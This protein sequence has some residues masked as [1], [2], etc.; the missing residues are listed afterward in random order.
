MTRRG[1]TNRNVRGSSRD[2]HRQRAEVDE[3]MLTVMDKASSVLLMSTKAANPFTSPTR[4][5]ILIV[6][7]AVAAFT[8]LL[9]MWFGPNQVAAFNGWPTVV[10]HTAPLSGQ[11]LHDY[12]CSEFVATGHTDY[13]AY[14]ANGC[15]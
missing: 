9:L 12:N 5:M 11:Q 1:T 2:R 10:Q 4:V 14:A 7:P 15:K 6:G 13:P 3:E 8:A